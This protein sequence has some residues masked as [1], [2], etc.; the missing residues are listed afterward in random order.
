MLS[1]GRKAGVEA[2]PPWTCD[3]HSQESALVRR[4]AAG[5]GQTHPAA[6]AAPLQ[7]GD[8]KAPLLGGVARRAGVGSP[9][10]DTPAGALYREGMEE[11]EA[12]ARA[13]VAALQAAN[14]PKWTDVLAAKTLIERTATRN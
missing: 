7:G 13:A 8:I 2:S 5:S 4:G 9:R 14:Q 3:A 10:I 11:Y 12:L 6:G 1:V